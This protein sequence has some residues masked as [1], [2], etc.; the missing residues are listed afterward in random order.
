MKNNTTRAEELIKRVRLAMSL[1]VD[2]PA[3]LCAHFSDVPVEEL[4]LAFHA[5]RILDG[6]KTTSSSQDEEE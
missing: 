1:G 3:D 2:T 4:F 5:S 6:E